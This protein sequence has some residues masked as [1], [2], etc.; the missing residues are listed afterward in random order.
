MVDVST[1]LRF[2]HADRVVQRL[3]LV[4]YPLPDGCC[5]AYYP[6]TQPL[7]ALEDHDPQSLTPSYKSIPVTLR[8]AQAPLAADRAIGKAGVQGVGSPV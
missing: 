5:A 7:V 3:T 8:H 2:A 6:E 4:S 1:A